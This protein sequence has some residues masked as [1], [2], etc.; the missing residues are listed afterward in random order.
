MLE[1]LTVTSHQETWLWIGTIGMA[2]GAIAIL[3]I[4]RGLGKHAH[5]AVASFFV[6]AIAA[7]F[8]LLMAFGQ[9]DVIVTADKLTI[10]PVGIVETVEAR[11]VYFAR[12]IDWVITTPLLL[13]GLLGIG[14]PAVSHAGEAVRQRTGLVAGVI[15]ADILMI[16]TGL[17]GALALDDTHKYVWFAVS[18]V[19]L[20]R[21]PVRHL[22]TGQDIG[23]SPGSWYRD[24][25]QQAAC[26][27]HG[28]LVLLPHPL[29]ARNR[30]NRDDQPGC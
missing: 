27:P 11:L 26:D 25:L 29:A 2:L 12:Y 3:A 5:H 23:E 15:G 13:I 16:V 17:F 18:S 4:G 7:C 19:F 20:L 8:Y 22:G 24:A 10:T 30:R 6:C 21:H 9:G 1:D 14:L 28:A